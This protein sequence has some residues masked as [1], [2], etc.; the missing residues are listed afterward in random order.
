MENII[1]ITSVK[2]GVGK[3][4]MALNLAGVY[5]FQGKKVL[6]ID[7]DLYSS[8]IAASLNLDPAN[9]FYTLSD[10]VSN[11][12]FTDLSRYVTKYN[13]QIDVIAGPKDVRVANRISSS[14]I[15]PILNKASILYDVV[16]VD[17]NHF[18]NEL[19]LTLL[20]NSDQILYVITNDPIDLKNMRSM[21]S[22]YKDMGRDN[23]SILLNE[24]TG[25]SKHLYKKNDVDKYIKHNIEFYV[26][27]KFYIKNISKYIME[28]KIITLDK[29]ARSSYRKGIS[30]I[31]YMALKLLIDKNKEE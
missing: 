16:I 20:Q 22:I 8:S 30:D 7:M 26:S 29:K 9:D 11:N 1:T 28:G 14:C 21:V 27:D 31:G 24:S 19:N 10:D 17:T 2:G 6:I 13:D 25:K 15:Q 12:R 3:S 18:I 5:A 4:T 23:Y